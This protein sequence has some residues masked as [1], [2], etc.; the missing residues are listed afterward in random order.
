MKLY[1]DEA[2]RIKLSTAAWLVNSIN[3]LGISV[4]SSKISRQC[5]WQ[6]KIPRVRNLE[7][8]KENLM[9]E[10]GNEKIKTPGWCLYKNEAKMYG[11]RWYAV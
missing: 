4:S 5:I 10:M 3:A 8:G 9:Q 6:Q 7:T 11:H 2:P 1:F